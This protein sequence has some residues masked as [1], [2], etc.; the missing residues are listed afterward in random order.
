MQLIWKI[1]FRI[2]L[3]IIA[4]LTFLFQ[5]SVQ[6]FFAV[7]KAEISFLWKLPGTWRKRKKW[8]HYDGELYPKLIIWQYFVR[9]KKTFADLI[10]TN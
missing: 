1:P 7:L 2:L 6:H 10:E 5:G 4:S 3:D 9:G 8:N